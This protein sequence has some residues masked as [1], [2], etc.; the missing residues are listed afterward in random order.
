VKPPY[1]GFNQ[2]QAAHTALTVVNFE[3]KKLMVGK[4]GEKSHF[5]NIPGGH[6]SLTHNEMNGDFLFKS[7]FKQLTPN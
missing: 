4:Y 5:S 3:G 1:S 6:F 2:A 7:P